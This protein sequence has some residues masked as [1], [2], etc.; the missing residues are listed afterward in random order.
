MIKNIKLLILCF[1]LIFG[2]S[3]END[4]LDIN[5]LIL[6]EN[7]TEVISSINKLG[8]S[9]LK[10]FDSDNT[11]ISIPSL[12]ASVSL[13][14]FYNGCNE[15]T[16]YEISNLLGLA[17]LDTDEI[18][19]SY[20]KILESFAAN[21]TSTRLQYKNSLWIDDN[22][23]LNITYSNLS[24][25]FFNTDIKNIN[26]DNNVK[27]S[28]NNWVMINSRSNI[29]NDFEDTV[30][31]D[32]QVVFVNVLY[33]NLSWE[34]NF[35]NSYDAS[36]YLSDESTIQTKYLNTT[37]TF[38]YLSLEDMEIVSI[39][40]D[41]KNY[42]VVI[43]LPKQNKTISDILANLNTSNWMT[44]NSKFKH[45]EI[46]L[47]I[48]FLDTE[49][50]TNLTGLLESIGLSNIFEQNNFSAF[51]NDI[52]NLYSTIFS[53]SKVIFSD[54]KAISINSNDITAHFNT[55]ETFSFCVNKPFF[56]AIKENS[57][58]CIITNGLVYTPQNT[59]N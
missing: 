46:N 59:I 30:I 2:F 42:D 11:N 35:S 43:I 51:S 44:W 6:D 4:S 55:S 57:S 27:D 24:K 40:S 3:C 58:N 52:D 38:D 45:Q 47:S 10:G 53:S 49:Y 5:S 9:L 20:K 18:N 50:S 56:Y 28:I 32:D 33:Y 22:I 36:F 31:E 39:P 14:T 54:A 1:F 7:E 21:E 41:N 29:F 26:F 19:N 8:F 12:C 13:T 34:H 15:N 48:P 37:G 25:F 17:N 16:K 23:D